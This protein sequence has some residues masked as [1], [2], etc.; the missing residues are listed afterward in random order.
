MPKYV[1][2]VFEFAGSDGQLS[3]QAGEL[4]EVTQEGEPNEWWE[5]VANGA[6][7]WFPSAYCS[8]PFEEGLD[9]VESENGESV[10]GGTQQ[11]RALYDFAPSAEDELGFRIGDLITVTESQGS[12]WMGSLDGR[13]GAFPSNYVELYE[14]GQRPT[15][16]SDV[17]E[18]PPRPRPRPRPVP[19]PFHA[20][21][22]APHRRTT[23]CQH[24]A[25]APPPRPLPLPLTRRH[26][27]G[28]PGP[29]HS[30]RGG[31]RLDAARR[32]G[33][34]AEELGHVRHGRL[35]AAVARR[36][37]QHAGLARPI[38]ANGRRRRRRVGRRAAGCRRRPLLPPPIP[39]P[40]RS[41]ASPAPAPPGPGPLAKS[42]LDHP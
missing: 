15:D 22:P 16:A 11:A 40:P 7:G 23:R 4:I 21:R 14:A 18:P 20:F 19:R 9:A 41:I 37:R 36:H 42:R 1:E 33:G 35:E 34:G 3:F 29:R 13:S 28:T 32:Q 26:H 25:P 30:A 12:W 2:A 24:S 17:R 5:G 27:H 8:P 10:H 31:A 39:P 6:S 38:A